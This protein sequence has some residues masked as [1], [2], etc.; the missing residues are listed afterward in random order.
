[1]EVHPSASK[2]LVVVSFCWEGFP[3]Y[4]C[5]S[6]PDGVSLNTAYNEQCTISARVFPYAQMHVQ[7]SLF[8]WKMEKGHKMARRTGPFGEEKCFSLFS[9]VSFCPRDIQVFKICKLAMWWR[10]IRNSQFQ[11]KV[12]VYLRGVS[13]TSDVARQV[14][15][16]DIQTPISN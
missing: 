11:L 3:L 13:R 9:N 1:M 6:F 15:T 14:L 10:H 4:L 8:G 7:E 12:T 16:V 2:V 5:S